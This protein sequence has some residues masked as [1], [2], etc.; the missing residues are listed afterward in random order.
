MP[1]SSDETGPLRS[2]I[3]ASKAAMPLDKASLRELE[4]HAQKH[5]G[6]VGITGYLTYRNEAFTQ[7]LEGPVDAVEALMERIRVDPRHTLTCEIELRPN[8]RCF[9]DWSMRL[10]NPLWFPSGSMLDSIDEVLA[11][12][13]VSERDVQA[14]RPSLEKLVAEVANHQ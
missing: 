2:L 13:P 8:N 1:T 7:V 14:V 10:L 9:P 5:N 3:Y 4:F 11:S 6:E 12:G